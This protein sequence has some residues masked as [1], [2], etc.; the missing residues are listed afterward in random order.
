MTAAVYARKSTSQ[1][2]VATDAKSVTRQ[3]DGARDNQFD[4][5]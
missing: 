1:D 5:I 2:D 4:E 3:I